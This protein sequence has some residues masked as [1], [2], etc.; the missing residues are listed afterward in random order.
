[1]PAEK[2]KQNSDF[3]LPVPL[4]S[5]DVW[6]GTDANVFIASFSYALNVV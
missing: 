4:K 5:T 2:Q 6:S 1:V 3:L